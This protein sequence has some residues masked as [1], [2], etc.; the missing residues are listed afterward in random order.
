MRLNIGTKGSRLI[1]IV[2]EEREICTTDERK[3]VLVL[4]SYEFR[5]NFNL[6]SE[7]PNLHSYE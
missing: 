4:Y 2:D 7:Q 3:K 1:L 5:R 6:T